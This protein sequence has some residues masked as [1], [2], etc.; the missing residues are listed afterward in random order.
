[1]FPRRGIRLSPRQEAPPIMSVLDTLGATLTLGTEWPHM[2]GTVEAI[3][4][5]GAGQNHAMAEE[6]ETSTAAPDWT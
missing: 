3:P 1:M 2:R 6:T 4:G 5:V